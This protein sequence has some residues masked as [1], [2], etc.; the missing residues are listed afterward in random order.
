MLINPAIALLKLVRQL[1]RRFIWR[2]C[3]QRMNRRM[4]ELARTIGTKLIPALGQATEA[5]DGLTAVRVEDY[6]ND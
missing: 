3:F 1:W 6:E 5:M 4:D 2:Y